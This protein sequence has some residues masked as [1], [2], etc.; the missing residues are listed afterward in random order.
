MSS[1]DFRTAPYCRAC[2]DSAQGERDRPHT[3]TP[4][5]TE[6]QRLQPKTNDDES[7][8]PRIINQML[9]RMEATI[10]TAA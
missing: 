4:H 10:R 1:P 5:P 7:A 8:N 2:E 3:E 9:I 6:A